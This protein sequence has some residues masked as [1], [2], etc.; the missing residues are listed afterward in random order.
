MSCCAVAFLSLSSWGRAQ[1]GCFRGPEAYK[2]LVLASVWTTFSG[3]LLPLESPDQVE[4]VDATVIACVLCMLEVNSGI[5][6]AAS[7]EIPHQC[8]GSFVQLIVHLFCSP[9]EDSQQALL[10]YWEGC[11]P[12]KEKSPAGRSDSCTVDKVVFLRPLKYLSMWS[13]LPLLPCCN[14]CLLL[15]QNSLLCSHSLQREWFALA[16]LQLYL[17]MSKNNFLMLF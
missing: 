8:D 17:L 3:P 5:R 1:G 4:P 9:F 13:A 11:C 15:G 14:F 12:G 16:L 7:A 10:L 2:I 6:K